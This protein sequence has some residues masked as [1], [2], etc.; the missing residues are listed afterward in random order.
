MWVRITQDDHSFSGHH[1]QV[2]S[3]V[4]FSIDITEL[5]FVM[6]MV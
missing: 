3:L 5:V 6:V 2:L 1:A 4:D